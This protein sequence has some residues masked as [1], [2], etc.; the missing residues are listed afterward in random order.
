M[1]LPSCLPWTY[2]LKTPLFHPCSGIMP[3]LFHNWLLPLLWHL[4]SFVSNT[5]FVV[6]LSVITLTLVFPQSL[7]LCLSWTCI[8]RPPHPFQFKSVVLPLPA[9]VRSLFLYRV[10]SLVLTRSF[11]VL[12][13]VTS[14][15]FV[16][17]RSFHDAYLMPTF[18]TTIFPISIWEWCLPTLPLVV[19]SPL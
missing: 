10:A 13:P 3:H 5:F 18:W 19:F 12:S 9:L 15:T 8:L 11:D 2:P 17:T 7:P 16:I 14:R 6:W 4:A 1:P